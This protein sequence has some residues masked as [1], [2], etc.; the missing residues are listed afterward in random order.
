MASISSLGI[1]SGLDLNGLLDQLRDAEREKLEPIVAQSEQ[2]QAR[3]S[4][5]GKLQ[6]AMT[7]FDDSVETLKDASLYESLSASGGGDTL[8]AS[9]DA[10][11]QPGSYSVEVSNLAKAGTLATQRVDA[12]DEAIV[13]AGGKLNL[14]FKGGDVPAVEVDIAADSTLEDIRDAINAKEGAG[15]SASIVNDGEGYRLALNSTETGVDA[16]IDSTNF[17]TLVAGNLAANPDNQITQPGED[18]A[19]KINGIDITSTTNE[20]TE[21]IQGVTLNLKE[22]TAADSPITLKVEQ[23]TLK[24]REA[25]SGFVKSYNA[26]KDTMGTLTSYNSETGQAGELN[27]DRTVRTVESRL[28]SVLSG[29]VP[30]GELNT[31][32]EVGITLQRDGTLELDEDALGEQVSGNMAALGE[33]FAG[34]EGS[35]GMAGR[36]DEAL[37]RMLDEESGLVARSIEGAEG[38]LERLGERYTRM[39]T[40]VERTVERYRAQFGQLDAMIANMNQTSSYLTQQFDALDAQL[41]RD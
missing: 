11:A 10:A 24:V 26:L 25:V 35:T 21:A 36:V 6:S 17:S 15:V 16:A 7:Q 19:L 32:S 37:G 39:E 22:T 40:S 27:G 1:G 13:D 5:L 41:G 2:Q 34:S 18:A 30:G 8:S 23:D 28:R 12:P 3:I 38:R 31:L 20:V 29:G 14:N 33:F 9:V 4:A